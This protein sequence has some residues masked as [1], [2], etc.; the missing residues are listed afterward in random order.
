MKRLWLQWSARID[1]LS[2]RERALAALA[3]SAAVVF[4]VYMGGIDPALTRERSLKTSIAQQRTQ[5][6]G[7]DV[8]VSE[9]EAAARVDPDAALRRQLAAR[10][11]DNDR[12]RAALRN[13]QLGLVQPERMSTLLQQLV[14]QN[15]KLRL[16]SL[17]TLPPAGTTDGTFVEAGTV[18]VETQTQAA[19]VVLSAIP[20]GTVAPQLAAAK[21][22]TP[23][24][25]R[26]GV[27]L[28]LQGGYADMVAYMEALE[29]LPT[30]L[31]W[32]RAALDA[33]EHDKATLTLT[34][35][36]LSLEEKWIAL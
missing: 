12:L 15:G 9:K 19:P 33:I 18:P 25:Y 10:Q 31:F 22:D 20:P 34:L 6:A 32:G 14:Q 21:P 24:L 30:Q 2:L 11:A 5:L 8:E 27:T 29:R 17:K 1:A 13:R 36:T 7:I 35:Y 16:L 26:H 23:L 3:G 28:V 4:L